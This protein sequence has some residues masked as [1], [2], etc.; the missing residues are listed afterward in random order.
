VVVNSEGLKSGFLGRGWQFPPTFSNGGAHMNMASGDALVKSALGV[1]L[2]T[3]KN[4]RLMYPHYYCNLNQFLFQNANY[5]L[6][7]QIKVTIE[8]AILHYEPR[9]KLHEIDV[10]PSPTNP[11]L[12]MVDIHYTVIQTN[13]RRNMVFP[14]YLNEGTQLKTPALGGS[15]GG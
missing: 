7:S 9:V 3:A 15:H 2:T 12:L 10:A 14:F 13:T 6:Y 11:T 5:Q 4:E 8:E 1:L